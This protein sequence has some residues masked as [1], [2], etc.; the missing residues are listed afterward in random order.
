MWMNNLNSQHLIISYAFGSKLTEDK[1]EVKIFLQH[2]LD[3][4]NPDVLDDVGDVVHSFSGAVQ[5]SRSTISVSDAEAFAA[6]GL[7]HTLRG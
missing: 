2:I 4:V 6:D 1:G 3:V 7:D 5:V